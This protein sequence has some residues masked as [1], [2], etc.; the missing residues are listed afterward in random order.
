M[1]AV[2]LGVLEEEDLTRWRQACGQFQAL[3]M[4]P[5]A[6]S[7]QET[8]GILMRYYR[9]IGEIHEKFNVPEGETIQIAPTTGQVFEDKRDG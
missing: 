3:E 4:N 2:V 8:E 7:A 1:R 6:Y 5:L 9:L